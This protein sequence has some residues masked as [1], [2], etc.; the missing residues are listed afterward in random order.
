MVKR[1]KKAKKVLTDVGLFSCLVLSAVVQ[2]VQSFAEVVLSPTGSG[3]YRYW[4]NK[5]SFSALYNGFASS[6]DSSDGLGSV[7]SVNS[8]V[9]YPLPPIT[10]SYYS[11]NAFNVFRNSGVNG[12]VDQYF[13]LE[14]TGTTLKVKD[15]DEIEMWKRRSSKGTWTESMNSNG[16][17]TSNFRDIFTKEKVTVTQ[18]S[19]F[20]YLI[21]KLNELDGPIVGTR[22]QE[23]RE[24]AAKI[25]LLAHRSEFEM[26][27]L[28]YE[29]SYGKTSWNYQRLLQELGKTEAE[30]EQDLSDLQ[31]QAEELKDPYGVSKFELT[32]T[33]DRTAKLDYFI[34]NKTKDHRYID[35]TETFYV[36]LSGCKFSTTPPGVDST[37]TYAKFT[38]GTELSEIIID[39]FSESDKTISAYLESTTP[40]LKVVSC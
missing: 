39:D 18:A 31:T 15:G 23:V 13:N 33:G 5:D 12:K 10:G 27:P 2:P 9:R 22:A 28:N 3:L 24:L 8:S 16:V 37:P 6:K 36:K 26:L 14:G 32:Q 35:P 21:H 11:T 4:K 25:S 1:V 38:M 17:Y 7:E 19:Q 34:W 40:C 30:L 29:S 20:S